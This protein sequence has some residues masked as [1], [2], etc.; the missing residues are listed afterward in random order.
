MKIEEVIDWILK[1]ILFTIPS[2]I[3]TAIVKKWIDAKDERIREVRKGLENMRKELSNLKENLP[4]E[5]VLFSN[6]NLV[7]HC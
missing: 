6:N 1:I 7:M 2:A 5:Y 3:A 4:K